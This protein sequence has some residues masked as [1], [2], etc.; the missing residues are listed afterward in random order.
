MDFTVN[1]EENFQTSLFVHSVNTRNKHY[2]HRPNANSSYFHKSTF[3]AGIRIFSS[4][5]H[6]LTSVEDEKIQFI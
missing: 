2:L 4:L 5:P 6:R 3:C 1:I